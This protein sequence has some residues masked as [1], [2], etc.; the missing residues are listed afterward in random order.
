[1]ITLHCIVHDQAKSFGQQPSNSLSLS[2]AG[3]AGQAEQLLTPVY[4]NPRVICIA[5]RSSQCM[6]T[7]T[8]D[9]YRQVQRS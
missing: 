2:M 6:R 5:S 4:S 7:G 9:G 3:K 8:G 1:M